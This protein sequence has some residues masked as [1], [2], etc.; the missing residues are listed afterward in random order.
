MHLKFFICL[1]LLSVACSGQRKEKTDFPYVIE[2]IIYYES[3][4]HADTSA[5]I[6]EAEDEFELTDHVFN[7]S[8]DIEVTKGITVWN[9]T[10]FK[11]NLMFEFEVTVVKKGGKNDRVSDLNCFWMASD[12]AFPDNFF[13]RS[14]WRKGI[15]WNY[16]SLNLYYVG[17]GGHNNTKTRMRK[18]NAIAAPVP[19]VLKEYND[20][21]HLIIPDKRSVI[22]IVSFDSIVAYYFNG[23]KLFELKEKQ[24][25]KEGYFGFRTINNHMKI[26]SFKVCSLS[27]GD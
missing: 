6:I 4:N 10:K 20:S 25:Y 14:T 8:L 3:F 1:I 7:G 19:P 23:E 17:Y 11:G 15:F 22:R 9:T 18:Y 16:Y 5:W 12:P 2:E 24:P 13:K 21:S 27:T 26:E